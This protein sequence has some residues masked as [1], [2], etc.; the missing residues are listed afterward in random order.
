M[1]LL[2][3]S[4]PLEGLGSHLCQAAAAAAAAAAAVVPCICGRVARG[5][6][7]LLST[8]PP[9]MVL[10]KNAYQYVNVVL[11]FVVMGQK[12]GLKV[13]QNDLKYACLHPK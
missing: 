13:S 10:R 5:G 4:V 3:R 9:V 2:T 12:F 6:R 7:S 11:G 8:Q 1:L